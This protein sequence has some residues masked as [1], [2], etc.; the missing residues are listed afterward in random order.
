MKKIVL[1]VLKFIMVTFVFIVVMFLFLW[2]IEPKFFAELMKV[3]L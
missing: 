2:M 3:K 1:G